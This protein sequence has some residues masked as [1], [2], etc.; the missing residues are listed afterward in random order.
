MLQGSCHHPSKEPGAGV[1][2]ATH[3]TQTLVFWN[4][5]DKN[6]SK[7]LNL[8]CKKCVLTLQVRK[9]PSCCMKQQ[10]LVRELSLS[11]GLSE[12]IE[13]LFLFASGEHALRD[14]VLPR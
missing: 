4:S 9:L 11:V 8:H 5:G 1:K 14:L 10:Y 7:A 12:L 2:K 3:H 13:E 6:R